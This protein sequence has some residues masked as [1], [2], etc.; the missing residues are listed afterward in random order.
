MVSAAIV[1]VQV[2]GG[3]GQVGAVHVAHLRGVGPGHK[4]VAHQAGGRRAPASPRSAAAT[5][6]RPALPHR[7]PSHVPER[8]QADGREGEGGGDA[9][10]GAQRRRAGRGD[11]AEEQVGRQPDDQQT[12]LGPAEPPAG[13]SGSRRRRARRP[14]GRRRAGRPGCS[15][16]PGR[17]ASRTCPPRRGVAGQR[18]AGRPPSAARCARTGHGRAR[19]RRR[20]WP[21]RE[22]T[23]GAA[24]ARATRAHSDRPV[25]R[26]LAS[27]RRW[28]SG[29]IQGEQ[30]GRSGGSAGP[31]DRCRARDPGRRPRRGTSRCRPR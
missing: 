23:M 31:S 2:A 13:R 26:R 19:W 15:A 6:A 11:G 1:G 27:R 5:A 3:L 22:R 18:R 10:D 4:V 7:P 17:P 8:R 28:K 25:G 12:V 16:T 30:A 21:P 14:A 24:T 9:A 29:K 20:R